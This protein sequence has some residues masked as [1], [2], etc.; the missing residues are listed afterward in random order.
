MSSV[1]YQRGIKF[2]TTTNKLLDDN[3]DHNNPFD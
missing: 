1:N 2:K 3:I